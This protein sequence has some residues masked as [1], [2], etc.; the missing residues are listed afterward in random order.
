MLEACK[1]VNHHQ[2]WFK[3]RFLFEGSGM[4]DM[5]H[6]L[7]LELSVLGSNLLQNSSFLHAGIITGSSNA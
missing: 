7:A 6:T 1:Y 4:E 2:V 3:S 5:S